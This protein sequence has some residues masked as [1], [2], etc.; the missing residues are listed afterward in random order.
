MNHP[1]SR[2]TK[3]RLTSRN[4]DKHV[5]YEESVQAVDTEA[6]F[7]ARTYEKI[8]GKAPVSLREDFCGS[9]LLCAEWVKKRGRTATGVD[10]DPDVLAWGKK[11]NLAKMGEPGD[12]VTLLRQDVR[13]KVPGTFD[14]TV[15][16]NFSYFVFKTRDDLR[17][18][19]ESARRTMKKDGL[20]FIDLYGGYESFK[21]MAERRRMKGFNYVWD[22]SKIDPITGFV[23]NYIHFEF[24][25]G[26]RMDRAFTYEWRLWTIPELREV[27][28][29]AG[30]SKSTVY[31]EDA[32]AN[33]EG[34]GRFRPK[35]T[36]EQEAAF[37]AYVI[38]EK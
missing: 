5:L 16:L 34:T 8:R 32:D 26:S 30:F 3:K 14:V 36:A 18:Y 38:S 6:A 37:V 2:R 22:Q 27:L 7:L 35:T 19:F 25:D 13:A 24:R 12:R 23:T 15:A 33:G 29:E 28:A 1:T 20:F 21:P 11:R 10:L 31:W 9:A 17:A 4:A